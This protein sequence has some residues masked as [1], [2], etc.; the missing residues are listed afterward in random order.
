MSYRVNPGQARPSS[1]S[2]EPVSCLPL[3]CLCSSSRQREPIFPSLTPVPLLMWGAFTWNTFLTIS[4]KSSHRLVHLLG[5]WSAFCFSH[6][7]SLQAS[8]GCLL[9]SEATLLPS[10]QL[11]AYGPPSLTRHCALR[12]RSASGPG[13]LPVNRCTGCFLE[14]TPGPAKAV[15]TAPTGHGTSAGWTT[16]CLR[17]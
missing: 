17:L 2:P 10:H 15:A 9:P 16:V 8:S 14:A 5:L 11:L 13:A 12:G 3:P 4:H 6:F 1:A 7:L